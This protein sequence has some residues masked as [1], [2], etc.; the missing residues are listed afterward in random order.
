MLLLQCNT[1]A[2]Y[3][4]E[5]SKCYYVPILHFLYAVQEY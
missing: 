4:Q 1:A 2:A 5:V 3:N